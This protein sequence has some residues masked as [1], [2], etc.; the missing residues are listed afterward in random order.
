MIAANTP[1]TAAHGVLSPA[2]CSSLTLCFF[3]PHDQQSTTQRSE[4]IQT[5]D[6]NFSRGIMPYV[7]ASCLN[8]HQKSWMVLIIIF[9]RVKFKRRILRIFVSG[10]LRSLSCHRP[11]RIQSESQ[12]LLLDQ[13]SPIVCLINELWFSPQFITVRSPNPECVPPTHP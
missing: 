8:L 13:I 11:Q 10:R 9:L 4:A 7:A 2:P 1:S 3:I 12:L 5:G 6:T